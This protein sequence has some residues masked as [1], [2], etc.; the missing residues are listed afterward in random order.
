M[1]GLLVKNCSWWP[2]SK[3][4]ALGICQAVKEYN[5]KTTYQGGVKVSYRPVVTRRYLTNGCEP[6]GL[7]VKSYR[8]SC[9]FFL[10][11]KWWPK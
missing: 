6:F 10:Q 4:V 9:I 8:Q 1:I 2:F 5:Y 7:F 11:E 3:G